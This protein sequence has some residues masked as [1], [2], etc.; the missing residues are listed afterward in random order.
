[1]KN[2]I[3]GF[4]SLLFVS[5]SVLADEVPGLT[6]EYVEPGST[7]YVQALST[8]GKIKFQDVDEVKHAV[9]EFKDSNVADE[10]LGAISA[11]G[12][13][14]F[15]NVNENDI[16][17]DVKE[18]APASAGITVTAYP[19]PTADHVHV[20][21]V[22]EGET[23]RI[24]TADGKLVVSTKEADIN[25]GGKPNGIYILQAGKEIVKI[26]KK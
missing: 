22:A 23:I 26:I 1:M 3:L 11:I 9:L 24:F 21:G 13:I 25:L 16:T 12:K 20:D 19:N 4:V 7:T 8:I 15:G 5:S 14:V 6:V 18:V 2:K 17:T 10:D